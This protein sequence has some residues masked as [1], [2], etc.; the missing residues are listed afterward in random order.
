[1]YGLVDFDPHGVAIM[2]TY[3]NGS[4]SLRHEENTALTQLSWLGPKSSDILGYQV[5]E[6]SSARECSPV[7][8]TLPLCTRERR[9]TVRLLSKTIEKEDES[10]E[11]ID[12]IRELQMMLLFNTKAEIQAVDDAGD[13]TRWLDNAL[14]RAM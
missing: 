5:G 6:L 4:R 3:K 10:F 11:H 8:A 13:L 2:L 7:D 12:I 9:E 14:I 1:M